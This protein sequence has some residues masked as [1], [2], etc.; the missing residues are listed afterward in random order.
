MSK[1]HRARLVDD[2]GLEGPFIIKASY[3]G[4]GIDYIYGTRDGKEELLAV[5][6]DGDAILATAAQ[7]WLGTRKIVPLEFVADAGPEVQA[8]WVAGASES[9]WDAQS[10]SSK[11]DAATRDAN[12][13]AEHHQETKHATAAAAHRRAAS[14]H[15]KTAALHDTEAREAA[16]SG[17][18]VSA[19]S[20]KRQ[21]EEARATQDKHS[22]QASAHDR[23]L[24]K[25]RTPTSDADK[26][27]DTAGDTDGD[28]DDAKAGQAAVAT[29]IV[30]SQDPSW[31]VKLRAMAE[32]RGITLEHAQAIIMGVVPPGAAGDIVAMNPFHEGGTGRFT[33]GSGGAKKLQDQGANAASEVAATSSKSAHAFQGSHAAASRAHLDAAAANEKVRQRSKA[34]FA[35]AVLRHDSLAAVAHSNEASNAEHNVNLHQRMA[36]EHDNRAASEA[37]HAI[38][39]GLAAQLPAP[40]AEKKAEQVKKSGLLG[41]A[42]GTLGRGTGTAVK[43]TGV[44]I[45]VGSAVSTPL[46]GPL[47]AAAAA[48]GVGVATVGY[49]I[50]RL[51]GGGK[52][53]DA[54][55][56]AAGAPA[57][58]APAKQSA[59]GAALADVESYASDKAAAHAKGMVDKFFGGKKPAPGQPPA[60][61]AKGNGVTL[62]Y[63]GNSPSNPANAGTSPARPAAPAAP[64]AQSS[65]V[66]TAT[67]VPE[68]P[69]R[70]AASS[71]PGG[72]GNG[73][74]QHLVDAFDKSRQSMVR[75]PDGG[76]PAQQRS[77][78]DTADALDRANQ[79]SRRAGTSSAQA[80]NSPSNR[81]EDSVGALE[82]AFRGPSNMDHVNRAIEEAQ[83]MDAVRRSGVNQPPPS[84]P[85]P[86]VAPVQFDTQ[87]AAQRV[88]ES[89]AEVIRKNTP[90]VR[91][92]TATGDPR[93][94]S[95]QLPVRPWEVAEASEKKSRGDIAAVAMAVA[96]VHASSDDVSRDELG[97]FS[98]K[99]SPTHSG[100]A[101][102]KGGKQIGSITPHGGTNGNMTGLVVTHGAGKESRVGPVV[103]TL[104]EAKKWLESQ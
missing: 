28:A 7:A 29:P 32:A 76:S 44:A 26:D 100:W 51:F 2:T 96:L 34:A 58:S 99:I 30:A 9:G 89:I 79:A 87:R 59:A 77:F 39:T 72:A 86:P 1:K 52:K 55:P 91:S 83:I 80:G 64:A 12:M 97:R 84:P 101:A 56:P 81:F 103:Q 66:Y 45:A 10:S 49:G 85:P 78:Q 24:K 33:S 88:N 38:S 53:P 16:A 92:R 95:R 13:P 50:N 94:P 4:T 25:L 48:A 102:W 93:P 23:S 42:V 57:A 98:V 82:R 73:S 40:A 5:D 90:P 69:A 68:P 43:Y 19:A 60:A 21:A 22:K 31:K 104:Q 17:D 61:P 15:E 27:G 36:M 63:T 11:A 65:P 75:Q 74:N 67:V 18:H 8:G 70:T 35:D 14:D 6:F 47:G 3:G 46:T 62:K 20:H 54:S 41:R 37:N 71:S